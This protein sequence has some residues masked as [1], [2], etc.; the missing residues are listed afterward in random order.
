MNLHIKIDDLFKSAKIEEWEKITQKDIRIATFKGFQAGSKRLN[1]II[2]EKIQEAFPKSR[3]FPDSFVYKIFFGTTS[4]LPSVLFFSKMPWAGVFEQD[5]II[6]GNPYLFIFLKPWKG[7]SRIPYKF[8]KRG[9]LKKFFSI[10]GYKT[11]LRPSAKGFTVF[12]KSANRS[13]P[14]NPEPVGVLVRQVKIK[15]RFSLLEIAERHKY[16]LREAI[17]EELDRL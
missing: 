2:R 13:L 8:I 17:Q 12:V 14:A 9:G 11:F 4:I 1:Q 3:R 10:K 5:T 7:Y 16:I 15:K 6:K